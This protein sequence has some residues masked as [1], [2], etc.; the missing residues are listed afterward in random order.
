MK[1]AMGSCHDPPSIVSDDDE[2]EVSAAGGAV[3]EALAE[4]LAEKIAGATASL[5]IRSEAHLSVFSNRA[6]H[7][8]ALYESPSLQQSISILISKDV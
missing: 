6:K 8:T 4:A 5:M 1:S 7:E 3:D 2:G